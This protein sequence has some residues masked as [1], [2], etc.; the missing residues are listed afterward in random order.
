[1]VLVVNTPKTAATTYLGK[2]VTAEKKLKCYL[3]C[4]IINYVEYFY[5]VSIKEYPIVNFQATAL[6][7]N[8]FY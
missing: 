6:A 5:L 3:D 7:E 2:Q 8:A 1:M 4:G